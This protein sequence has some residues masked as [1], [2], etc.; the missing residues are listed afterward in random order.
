MSGTVWLVD[1]D[2]VAYQAC[3]A[4]SRVLREDDGS[5]W[6]LSTE[7][8]CKERADAIIQEWTK[9]DRAGD[10]IVAFSQGAPF[11]RIVWE[12]YKLHRHGKPKPPFYAE[13][14]AHLQDRYGS[15]SNWGLEADDFL[16]I[17]ATNPDFAPEKD[18]IIVS[19]DKDF[20]AIPGLLLN[21]RKGGAIMPIS[22]QSAD[23]AWMMQTLTGDS[24]DG[25]PGCPTIGPKRA[26]RA[27]A[28]F[29][30]QYSYFGRMCEETWKPIRAVFE[31]AGLSEAF[32]L[33]QAR[34]A[35]I[36]RFS[37]RTQ[38][39][40][41][42]LWEPTNTKNERISLRAWERASLKGGSQKFI[43]KMQKKLR[44]TP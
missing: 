26:K 15:F 24:V 28:E 37:D 41:V 12:D 38:K 7:R 17:A 39:D 3:A 5:L 20:L 36:L 16:G 11:R 42:I 40:E 27:I 35:R 8:G 18:K 31:A 21:P 23:T 2:I 33:S 1:G 43:E 22:E 6:D 19:I 32:A 34:C 9:T 29:S 13:T 25:Y 14:V 10:I 4:E 44:I 30:K